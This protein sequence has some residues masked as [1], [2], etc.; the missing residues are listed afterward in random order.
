[1]KNNQFSFTEEPFHS[2][3]M[4]QA[5]HSDDQPSRSSQNPF[6]EEKPQELHG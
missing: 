4:T 6:L 3:V 2:P 1:M 5:V